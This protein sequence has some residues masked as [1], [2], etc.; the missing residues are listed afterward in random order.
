[1]RLSFKNTAGRVFEEVIKPS[2]TRAINN[3]LYKRWVASREA[4]VDKLSNGRLAYVHVRG[5]NDPSFRQVYSSL[6]SK[7]FVKEAVVIDTRF[8][9]GGCLHNDLAKLLMGE[10]YFSMHVRG[11]KYHG[12]PLDQWNKP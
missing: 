9:G 8:N 11:G 7:H 10:E 12:D 5:M 2:S 1:M 6:L 4:L 3:L